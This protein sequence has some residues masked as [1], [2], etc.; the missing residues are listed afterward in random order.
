MNIPLE[1]ASEDNLAYYNSRFVKKDGI[2]QIRS[3][4]NLP[5]SVVRFDPN[6]VE[7]YLSRPK[8]G[9]GFYLEVHDA[10]HFWSSLN[11]ESRGFVVLGKKVGESY[12]LTAYS[13]PYGVGIYTAGGTIHYDGSLIGEQFVIYTVT[14]NFS[15]VH[16]KNKKGNIVSF[17]V[18]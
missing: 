13:I 12:H 16:V 18:V 17:K 5:V 1:V 14:P 6:Y 10:P 2:V 4:K 7:G 8:L 15:T 11:K 9:G 3:K